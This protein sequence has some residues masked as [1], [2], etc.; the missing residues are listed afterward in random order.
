MKSREVHEKIMNAKVG[1]FTAKEIRRLMHI[2]EILE[3]FEGRDGFVLKTDLMGEYQDSKSLITFDCPAGHHD[4]SATRAYFL[5]SGCI[6]CKDSQHI[7]TL[8]T[9]KPRSLYYGRATLKGETFWKIGISYNHA[10]IRLQRYFGLDFEKEGTYETEVIWQ[11]WFDDAPMAQ[12]IETLIKRTFNPVMRGE[13]LEFDALSLAPIDDLNSDADWAVWLSDK[14]YPAAKYPRHQCFQW[15]SAR[16]S[17][18][19]I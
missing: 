3:A 9:G 12:K 4:I 5:K 8:L 16:E 17:R 11:K 14:K 19:R 2:Y 7:R 15:P 1:E 13:A 18:L 10:D 6:V